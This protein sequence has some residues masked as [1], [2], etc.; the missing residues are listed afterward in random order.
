[1]T[2]RR[3]VCFVTSE[4]QPLTSGGIGTLIHNL[5]VASDSAFQFHVL[6]PSWSTITLDAFDRAFGGRAEL[7]QA[8]ALGI[9]AAYP[10][11]QAFT[12]SPSHADS[13]E[14]CLELVRLEE[15]GLVFAAVEFADFLGWAFCSTQQKRLGL[16]FQETAIGVRLHGTASLIQTV[17]GSASTLNELTVLELERKSLED[18]DVVVAHLGAVADRYREHYGFSAAWRDRVV[19]EFPPVTVGSAQTNAARPPEDLLFL[20]KLQPV[21]RPDLF[22]RGAATFMLANSAFTGRAILACH[23]ATS[24]EAHSL[25]QMVP[26]PI[27]DRFEFTQSAGR[28][29]LMAHGVVVIP[30]DYESLNLTA[31]EA[32]AAGSTL[33]LNEKCPAFG[34]GS[35]FKDG[36]NAYLFDG[37]SDGL[38][39]ALARAFKAPIQRSLRPDADAPWFKRRWGAPRKPSQE[40]PL[41]SVVITNFNLGEY[42]PSALK[43]LSASEYR[44]LEIILV[45]D[46]STNR[47][48]QSLIEE[49]R[50]T[51]TGAPLTVVQNPVNRGLAASR[52]IGF[53][54]ATGTFVMSLDADDCIGPRFIGTAVKALQAQPDFGV[55]VPT[56]AYFETDE[57]LGTEQRGHQVFLGNTQTL[58]LVDNRMSSATALMRRSLFEQVSYDETLDSYEDWSLYLR[59]ALGGVR[60]LVANEIG[61]YYRLREGSMIRGL[62]HVKHERLL[63]RI[64]RSLPRPLPTSVRLEG[65]P[66]LL[67]WWGG[68]PE[69]PPLRHVV[70]DAL[71]DAIKR[72]PMLHQTLKTASKALAALKRRAGR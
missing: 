39:A 2:A 12:D 8:R 11:R 44:H 33:V 31:Y 41:V 63:A 28:A 64:Y 55:V 4:L 40:S 16:S 62:S 54:R 10:P 7:H 45:D 19:V 50:H 57:G 42:L 9:D 71:N 15:S 67:S 36:K 18:A 25:R 14:L 38:A 46:A 37:T 61:F 52:N 3:H 32:A 68:H 43:S 6:V 29:E 53:A 1:M 34:P 22:I 24:P 56:S 59:L 20:T 35:P 48:D 26:E 51:K 23:G 17:E 49:L 47:L 65:L 72:Q 21:K 58:G 60:F 5:I 70:V 69:V 66:I 27:R 30:S 13:L